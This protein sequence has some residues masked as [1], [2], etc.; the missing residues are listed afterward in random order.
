VPVA[1][2]SGVA[3]RLPPRSK[4]LR[5]SLPP[6]IFHARVFISRLIPFL[7]AMAPYFQFHDAWFQVLNLRVLFLNWAVSFCHA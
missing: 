7:P 5:A 6:S 4:T 2:E 1:S 3:L